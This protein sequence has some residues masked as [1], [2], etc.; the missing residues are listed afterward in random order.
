MSVTNSDWNASLFDDDEKESA[1]GLLPN[2]LFPFLRLLMVKSSETGLPI[3]EP[4]GP[5][6][7]DLALFIATPRFTA[8]I[9][10]QS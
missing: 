6:E 7:K 1:A 5:P 9:S 4:A 8:L 10:R 2:S 3:G